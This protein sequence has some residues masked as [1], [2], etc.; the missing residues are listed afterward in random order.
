MSLLLGI[1][2]GL[3][4]IGILVVVHE[5]GH[6]L[7]AKLFHI[8]APVFS[9]GMGH[10]LFGFEYK[11]TDFR[12]SALPLGGYVQLAGVDPF[13]EVDPDG[14]FVP[15]EENF[16][17]RPVYQRLLV[18]VAGPAMNLLLPIPLFALVYMIGQPTPDT[19]IG[20]VLP[21]T[22]AVELGLQPGDRI[23]SLAGHELD[24]WTDMPYIRDDLVGNEV[25]AVIERDGETFEVVFPADSFRYSFD[26]FLD[27]ERAGVKHT[28][29]ST[30][31]GVDDPTSPAGLAG[32]KT[33]D[34]ITAVDGTEVEAWNEL[35]RLLTAGSPHELVIQR[36]SKAPANP[37]D[38]GAEKPT[39]EELTV[40]IDPGASWMAPADDPAVHPAWGLVP[41][42]LYT[43]AIVKDS[44]AMEAGIEPGDR[45]FSVDGQPIRSWDE[46]TWLVAAT[47]EV[48]GADANP[49]PID[50]TVVREGERLTKTFTPRLKRE[51]VRGEPHW[52]PIMGVYA[53]PNAYERGTFIDYKYPLVQAVPMA[54]DETTTAVK[55]IFRILGSLVTTQLK[56]QEAVGGPIAMVQLATQAVDIGLLELMRTAAMISVSLGIVNLLPVPV[57]DGGH[58]VFYS[59]EGLRGR[60]LPLALRERI[61]MI[62]V[63]VLSVVML[64][65][66]VMDINRWLEMGLGT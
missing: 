66:I 40:Q 43:G 60:P 25:T 35:D 51:V 48:A 1:P 56:P 26:G 19:V 29:K 14:T 57:L 16:M 32:L 62:G 41:I 13:G 30:R 17:N 45:L 54:L 53:Y 10:R 11:G 44:A 37:E 31:V 61:Q 22:P 42:Q 58:I 55:K 5:F 63:L 50:L 52:R 24:V 47:V 65:V 18:M 49:R 20:Q 28:L 23:L 12:L 34:R 4:M 38:K 64:L 7:V 6:F 15:P 3:L 9:V 39:F 36:A 27:I 2:A 33:G 8:G 21:G 46:V 59:I